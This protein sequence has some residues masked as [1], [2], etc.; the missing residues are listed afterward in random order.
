MKEQDIIGYIIWIENDGSDWIARGHTM[1][2][3]FMECYNKVLMITTSK[4]YTNPV[5]SLSTAIAS[6]NKH[7]ACCIN[8]KKDERIWI[9]VIY[10]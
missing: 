3:T 8:N 5:T 7:G 1:Y 6:I 9:K 10:N 2:S 4:N